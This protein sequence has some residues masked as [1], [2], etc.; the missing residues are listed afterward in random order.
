MHL[1]NESTPDTI[2]S[3]EALPK[4]GGPI[5]LMVREEDAKR[6][7]ELLSEDFDDDLDG[8]NPAIV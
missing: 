6:A 1:A 3:K 7:G 8:S 2:T 5:Q 4:L